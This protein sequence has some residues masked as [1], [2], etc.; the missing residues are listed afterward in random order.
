MFRGF[1]FFFPPST[2]F[3]HK[4]HVPVLFIFIYWFL[5]IAN[6]PDEPNSG[7]AGRGTS[8]PL[9]WDFSRNSA[10][11]GLVNGELRVVPAFKMFVPR[12]NPGF[13]LLDS[14]SSTCILA[15]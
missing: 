3:I 7:S 4:C 6:S 15:A 8:K 11:P 12:V 9:F 5:V 14:G 10:L 1:F 2:A 13:L